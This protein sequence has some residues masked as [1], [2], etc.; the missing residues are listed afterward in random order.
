MNKDM[1]DFYEE[2]ES[3]NIR[4]FLRHLISYW[5]YFVL[6]A[7]IGLLSAYL[8][9]KTQQDEYSMTASVLIKED[10]KG[11]GLD[12]LFDGFDMGGKSK[13]QNHIGVMKS[14]TIVQS[15]LLQMDMQSTWY[16]PGFFKD[17]E[18]Y[19]T[20]ELQVSNDNKA[21]NPC[22][23]P[24]HIQIIDENRYSISVDDKYIPKGEHEAIEVNV[25]GMASFGQ[26]FVNEYFAFTINKITQPKEKKYIFTF[27][28]MTAMTLA[29]QE[30]LSVS[31]ID[32][33]ADLINLSIKGATPAK[34]VDFMNA[35]IKQYSIFGLNIKNRTSENMVA[36]IDKQM[37]GVVDSLKT[38]GE[39]FSS[40]RSK[41]STVN[42]EGESMLVVQ[43]LEKLESDYYMANM[44]ADYYTNLSSYMDDANKMKEMPSPSVVGITDMG[45]NALVVRLGDLYARRGVLAVVAIGKNPS[46][47]IVNEEIRQARMSLSENI[48]NLM[49]NSNIEIEN[50]KRQK[51]KIETQLK[52]LPAKE[53]ELINIKRNF[54]INNELFTFLLK[55]RAEAAITAAS[56]VS[57]VEVVDEARVETAVLVGPRKM[58]NMIIGLILGLGFPFAFIVLADFFNNTVRSRKEIEK[59]CKISIYGA[60][61]HSENLVDLQVHKYP[62][63]MV[64]ESFRS[65]RTN[66]HYLLTEKDEKVIAVHSAVPAEGKSF[67]SVNL[68]SIL[69]MG[70]KKVVLVGAD[71]RKP[72]L[73][74]IFDKPNMKGLSTLMINDSS[75]EEIIL[76][77][78]VKNLSLVCSG[79]VPPNPSELLARKEFEAFVNK[80]KED[81]DYVIIDNAPALLVTDANIVAGSA[82][83][84]LFVVRHAF[85]K[86]E[87]IKMLDSIVDKSKMKNV[88][89]L[90]NDERNDAL[91]YSY[92]DSGYYGEDF[93]KKSFFRNLGNM[94][95]K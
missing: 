80:L 57:D 20:C 74:N 22:G 38:A 65:L 39:S 76:E 37:Q 58:I 61:S 69:A 83:A 78:E 70:G 95:K 3:T 7:C 13:I 85:S 92:S 54:D 66:L 88:G 48:K 12:A 63:S 31:L 73:H 64:A 89:V 15:A 2:E 60:V 4:E 24:V 26:P 55:K 59:D 21:L 56:N 90:Y 49:L 25:R 33:K 81:F 14:F 1:M 40:F 29:Y 77:T 43:T 50:I 46:L 75:Y 68:A 94:F 36:F 10:A 17:V 23:L 11:G 32:K 52:S 5:K 71:L 53:Q 41:N 86:I 79:P 35:L 45:L 42:L 30:K 27:N 87:H 91:S 16:L 82:D 9:T 72:R 62:R 28:D 51:D 47:L 34:E 8:G 93:V 18:I 44:R 6:C 19:K 67:C 84:N